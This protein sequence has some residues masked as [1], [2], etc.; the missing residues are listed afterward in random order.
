MKNRGLF[1]SLIATLLVSLTANAHATRTYFGTWEAKG[2]YTAELDVEKGTLTEPKLA[3]ELLNPG[4]V[5][6]HPNGKYLYSVSFDDRRDNGDV[7]AM[8][9]QADGSLSLINKHSAE[10]IAPCHISI[11]PSGQCLMVANYNTGNVASFRIHEDGSL[12]EAK[13]IH[14]HEGS[15]VHPRQKGPH[16]HSIFP[17]PAGTFAYSPDLGI[18]KVMIY[19]LDAKAGT[20]TPAGEAKIPGEAMGPR[21]MKWAAD[22]KTAYV[23][24]E[25]DM[26]ISIFKPGQKAESM[27]H[28][29]TVSVLAEDG[30]KE[31]MSCAE[32]RIHPNGKF[33]YASN[34]DLEQRGRDSISVF[35]RFEDGMDL[36]ETVPVGVS[37]PRNFNLDPS[38][39]WL[40]AGGQ[41]SHDLAILKINPKTGRLTKTG[42][43]IPFPGAPI[44]IEFSAP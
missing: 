14:Q 28:V 32:I 15:G 27:G 6:I 35:S 17:N 36:L 13:S 34:R 16:A 22:G 12:S 18:D 4:F 24:N 26:S 43:P 40:I 5:A 7:A 44:C 2:I 30:D 3:I 33:I 31:R 10:G 20:L 39:Q 1:N 8:A 9:I 21:H 29:K 41:K 38:G 25:L 42:E 11:D 37:V 19:A 23:L